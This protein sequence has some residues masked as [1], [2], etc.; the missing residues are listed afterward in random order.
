MRQI[1]IQNDGKPGYTTQ[2][3]DAE[4]GEKLDFQVTEITIKAK[5]EM[6]Y[7]ILTSLFP[8]IDVIADAEIKH[9]CPCCGKALKE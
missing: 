6:P 4:T 7:A 2:V 9:V 5:D 8:V 1:R 3:T